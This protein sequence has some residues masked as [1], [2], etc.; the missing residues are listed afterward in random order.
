MENL[1]LIIVGTLITVVIIAVGT[2]LIWKRKPRHRR[3]RSHA[4]MTVRPEDDL[5]TD[6]YFDENT[7]NSPPVGTPD[8][9]FDEPPPV[10]EVQPTNPKE[11]A[12]ITEEPKKQPETP[13]EETSQ[14]E[15]SL[16]TE[17]EEESPPKSPAPKT[18]R[19]SEMLIMLYVLA[20]PETSFG[21]R[22]ILTL[23]EK[24]GLKYGK[25]KIFH[26]Y[27]IGDIKLNQAI[28]SIA[29]L[30]EPG[31]FD[32]QRMS[33]FTSPGLVLFMR[34]PGPF[35]GR[36][37]FELMLNSAQKIAEVLEG[38]LEDERHNPV[39]QK[40]ITNLRNRIANF[41]QRSTHLSMLKRFT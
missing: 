38:I 22:E 24:L 16:Q 15:T 25:M 12:S 10:T 14:P 30:V 17:E 32:P 3:K 20:K 27:G 26:H 6:N 31:T 5:Y 18:E 8:P 9:L 35:G 23:L 2:I 40:T 29:N 1:F 7:Q 37:A 19:Q 4:E 36:V 41:E 28:F 39:T 34:L 21:G 33:D 13:I 11:T